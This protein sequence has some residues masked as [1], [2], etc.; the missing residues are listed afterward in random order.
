[1]VVV[2][3]VVV[4]VYVRPGPGQGRGRLVAS[5]TVLGHG[6][7]QSGMRGMRVA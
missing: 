2:V 3:V 6:S 5:R 4:V 7:V 1:M